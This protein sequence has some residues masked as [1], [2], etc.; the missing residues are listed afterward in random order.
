[1]AC[2]LGRLASVAPSTTK[3]LAPSTTSKSVASRLAA[4]ASRSCLSTSAVQKR[5]GLGASQT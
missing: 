5:S 1:M 4:H 3:Q 2:N